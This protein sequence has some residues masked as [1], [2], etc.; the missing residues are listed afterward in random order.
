[1]KKIIFVLILLASQSTFGMEIPEIGIEDNYSADDI[2]A[3][4]IFSLSHAKNLVLEEKYEEAAIT[5][6][7]IIS[8]FADP[9]AC[10]IAHFCLGWLYKEGHLDTDRFADFAFVAFS[11]AKK[12]PMSDAMRQKN[13]SC[14]DEVVPLYTHYL[15]RLQS[16][17]KP[18]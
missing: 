3:L 9:Q 17:R 5:Y 15:Y 13:Q 1:M 8:E 10:A 11:L 16:R 2:Q 6:R 7:S 12:Y 4:N 14:M 18:Q